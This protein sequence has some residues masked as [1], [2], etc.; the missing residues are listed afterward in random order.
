VAGTALTPN[1]WLG[2]RNM[3]GLLLIIAAFQIAPLRG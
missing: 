3:H 1:R 2:L